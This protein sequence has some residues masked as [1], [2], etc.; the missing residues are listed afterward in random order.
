MKN[1]RLNDDRPT[2]AAVCAWEQSDWRCCRRC[3][4]D[5][6]PARRC[7]SGTGRTPVRRRR[8]PEVDLPPL[9]G[10]PP[11]AQLTSRFRYT[12]HTWRH[13]PTGSSSS[14]VVRLELKCHRRK[15]D[16]A[17][18]AQSTIRLYKEMS[19]EPAAAAAAAAASA[20]QNTTLH[21]CQLTARSLAFHSNADRSTVDQSRKFFFHLP[22][23]LLSRLQKWPTLKK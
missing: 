20:E 16:H 4:R 22:T 3:R 19:T 23:I 10:R 21:W 18:Q 15:S 14:Y 11:R 7:C 1:P 9:R 6:L 17:T 8:G 12:R 2:S 5:R 13:S